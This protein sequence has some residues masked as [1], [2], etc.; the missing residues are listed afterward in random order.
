MQ[1]DCEL[2]WLRLF[3]GEVIVE[4]EG[5]SAE[6]APGFVRSRMIQRRTPEIMPPQIQPGCRRPQILIVY[7]GSAVSIQLQKSIFT[8]CDQFL[9]VASSFIGRININTNKGP[10]EIISITQ[11]KCYE[12]SYFH[13]LCCVVY[14]AENDLIKL[15]LL[16]LPSFSKTVTFLFFRFNG[17]CMCNPITIIYQY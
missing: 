1:Y 4:A 10:T 17:T 16:F 8:T 12:L 5:E 15:L 2:K 6:G 14:Q 9:H 7:N 13:T 3:T 11:D